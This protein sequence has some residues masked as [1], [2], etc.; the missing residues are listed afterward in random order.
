M[1]AKERGASFSAITLLCH[2]AAETA[3]L[4]SRKGAGLGLI[5]GL[6]FF[7]FSFLFLSISFLIFFLGFSPLQFWW[8]N[9]A[10][11]Q[12]AGALQVCFLAVPGHDTCHLGHRICLTTCTGSFLPFIDS[13]DETFPFG[14]GG[15]KTR[16][17]KKDLGI[18]DRWKTQ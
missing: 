9:P 11:E 1:I 14:Q 6:L 12:E 3:R 4:I 7:P 10:R 15:E 16:T 18:L 8:S 13:S 2:P 17:A 5:C